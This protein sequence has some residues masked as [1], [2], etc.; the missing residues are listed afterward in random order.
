MPIAIDFHVHP[1]IQEAC[2]ALAG[3]PEETTRFFRAP[4]PLVDVDETAAHYRRLGLVGVLLGTDAETTTGVPAVPNDYIAAAVRRHPDVFVGFAGVDPWKG[5]TAVA[6]LE[7][8]VRDLG[9]RGLK[10]HPGRQQFYPDD[11][12]FRP[13]WE[14]CVALGIPVLL[15]TGMM[16]AGAGTPGGGRLTLQY[17]RPIPH[18]DDLAADFP[19]L[20]IVAAH[21]SWPWQAEMLAVA[22]H[23]ANVYIDLSGWSPRYFP[24]ELVHHANTLL[25]D[26]CLFGSDYPFLPPERWLADFAQAPFRDEVRPQLLYENAQRLLAQTGPVPGFS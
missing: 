7:R 26:R 15:H 21:P 25:R 22:R 17:T 1:A 19:D 13:L 3:P 10:L 8:A 20:T 6:E 4:V 16:A 18:I 11:P 24:P 9:L 5:A 12:R 2:E 14:R 23:K